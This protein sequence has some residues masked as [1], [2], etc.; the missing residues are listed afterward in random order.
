MGKTDADLL[1]DRPHRYVEVLET[2]CSR[3]ERGWL[4]RGWLERDGTRLA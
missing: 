2:S 3:D 1:H 4:E